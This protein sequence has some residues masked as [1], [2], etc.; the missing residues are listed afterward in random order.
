MSATTWTLAYRKRTANRFQRMTNWEGTWAQARE[1]AV[2][3]GE[4]HPE[5]DIWYV[6]TQASDAN[7]A[8]EDIGNILVESGRRVR[9]RENGTAPEWLLARVPSATE[10]QERWEMTAQ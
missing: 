5:L 8:P 2:I 1:L 4:A 7:G 6:P 9:I 3:F 10:A